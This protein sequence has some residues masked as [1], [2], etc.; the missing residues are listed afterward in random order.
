MEH[1]ATRRFTHEAQMRGAQCVLALCCECRRPCDTLA[2]RTAQ[3]AA[4]ICAPPLQ[5]SK[6]T[7]R[8]S[9]GALP[10]AQRFF[11][12]SGITPLT[13]VVWVGSAGR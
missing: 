1:P 5:P 3:M 12:P 11:T 2:R 13:R 10:M 9:G 4:R 7:A 8:V 6:T